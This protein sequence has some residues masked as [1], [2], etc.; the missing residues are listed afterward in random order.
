MLHDNDALL[1]NYCPHFLALVPRRT[2]TELLSNEIKERKLELENV[3]VALRTTQSL[4][5]T[6][7]IRSINLGVLRLRTA[8]DHNRLDRLASSFALWAGMRSA[9]ALRPEEAM[10]HLALANEAILEQ[11]QAQSASSAE[12]AKVYALLTEAGSFTRALTEK[13]VAGIQSS[14]DQTSPAMKAQRQPEIALEA[15]CARKGSGE[16]FRTPTDTVYGEEATVSDMRCV[17][18]KNDEGT[19]EHRVAGRGEQV[20][21]SEPQYVDHAAQRVDRGVSKGM[22]VAPQ[23]P[24]RSSLGRSSAH[25]YPWS[26]NQVDGARH[27]QSSH[28]KR[29]PK[30]HGGRCTLGAPETCEVPPATHERRT[31]DGQRAGINEPSSD[32][33][34][35]ATGDAPDLPRLML[36]L[37]VAVG[38]ELYSVGERLMRCVEADHREIHG[39]PYRPLPLTGAE[40]DQFRACLEDAT[41][42]PLRNGVLA[43]LKAQDSYRAV[44]IDR[45]RSG[46]P[47]RKN[48]NGSGCL[49]VDESDSGGGVTNRTPMMGKEKDVRRGLKKRFDLSS[50]STGPLSSPA[51]KAM[52]AR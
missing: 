20:T 33:L 23:A 40:R 34:S 15:Y 50:L 49:K 12:Q 4:A 35:I 43:L 27:G 26:E 6:V 22:P 52:A 28:K 9:S 13:G 30:E 1:E 29:A 17:L 3:R 18:H 31:S 38:Q 42:G 8:L 21:R 36:A 19:I 41:D 10:G 48:C 32:H 44:T 5:S 7:R 25:A 16:G 46:N 11:S 2:T 45:D 14:S 47:T 24:D 51:E 39:R 37:R